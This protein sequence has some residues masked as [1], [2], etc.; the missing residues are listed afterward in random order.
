MSHRHCEQRLLT[1]AALR[2]HY[3][4]PLDDVLSECLSQTPS[5]VGCGDGLPPFF[6]RKLAAEEGTYVN[7]C[8]RRV[9]GRLLDTA[10]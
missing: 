2:S 6:A 7:V 10:A 8:L 9:A 1:R 3:D 4:I 5:P